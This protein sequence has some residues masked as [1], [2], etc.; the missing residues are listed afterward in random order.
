MA[1]KI[2]KMILSVACLCSGAGAADSRLEQAW[3]CLQEDIKTHRQA[4]KDKDHKLVVGSNRVPQMEPHFLTTPLWLGGKRENIRYKTDITT[5]DITDHWMYGYPH[6]QG[7]ALTYDFGTEQIQ[8][9]YFERFPT[10][11]QKTRNMHE[12][13]LGKCIENVSSFLTLNAPLQIEWQPFCC[14][15]GTPYKPL[16]RQQKFTEQNPFTGYFELNLAFAAATLACQKKVKFEGNF[17]QEVVE[18]AQQMSKKLEELLSFYAQQG[19]GDLDLLKKRLDQDLWVLEMMTHNERKGIFKCSP[20]APFQE[21]SDSLKYVGWIPHS[22]SLKA[23]TCI[24]IPTPEGEMIGTVY[25]FES[26]VKNSL[27]NFLLSDF[28]VTQNTPLVK[29]YL[30]TIGFTDLTINRTTSSVNGR[31]NVWIIKGIKKSS[32]P[33]WARLPN[34]LKTLILREVHF[35]ALFDLRLVS[36]SWREAVD[37]LTQIDTYNTDREV[38][39]HTIISSFKDWPSH[40]RNLKALNWS[41]ATLGTKT[42][43]LLGRGLIAHKF[44]KNLTLQNNNLGGDFIQGI[45]EGIIKNWK[46]ESLDLSHN[47]LG[48]EIGKLDHGEPID[49]KVLVKFKPLDDKYEPK[50]RDTLTSKGGMAL[51][52]LMKDVHFLKKLSLENCGLT[53]GD[54]YLISGVLADIKYNRCNCRIDFSNNSPS[55][56]SLINRLKKEKYGFFFAYEQILTDENVIFEKAILFTSEEARYGRYGIHLSPY[57]LDESPLGYRWYYGE[58]PEVTPGLK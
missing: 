21:F 25:D 12:N 2:I 46:L 23:G 49:D 5:M 30:E 10:W 44:M 29:S 40:F 39:P 45:S 11:N 4:T 27:F 8:E 35:T 6:I 36:T 26:Y 57:M 58:Q 18:E 51:A 15:F 14:Y 33:D 38:T 56:E 19:V 7:D 13:Y 3:K 17:T 28:T 16:K 53:G 55:F 24:K 22:H 50:L 54:I 37:A 31:T 1:N 52:H 41:N 48:N 43:S 32:L 42:T 34:D 9:A 47:P 20:N